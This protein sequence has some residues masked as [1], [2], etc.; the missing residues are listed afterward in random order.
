M[1]ATFD[2]QSHI[3]YAAME[4]STT[5]LHVVVQFY[6]FDMS[7]TILRRYDDDCEDC[8]NSVHLNI[9]DSRLILTV[10]LDGCNV[11]LQNPSTINFGW[12]E[13][14]FS[15]TEN[16]VT[17]QLNNHQTSKFVKCFVSTLT[18]NLDQVTNI[19]E[20]FEG[21]IKKFDVNFI[22]YALTINDKFSDTMYLPYATFN[23]VFELSEEQLYS[24]LFDTIKIPF[25]QS[26]SNWKLELYARFEILAR[27][28]FISIRSATTDY[29]M[30]VEINNDILKLKIKLDEYLNEVSIK[31]EAID[32]SWIHLEIEQHN[33]SWC[34]SVNDDKRTLIMPTD[35]FDELC[36]THLYIDMPYNEV[37]MTSENDV[38]EL[39][40]IFISE[41]MYEDLDIVWVKSNQL[42]L[43]RVDCNM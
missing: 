37:T 25:P 33:N 18:L 39:N 36:D 23:T 6:P 12:N 35:V 20:G 42:D 15:I 8:G 10:I 5:L 26:C 31:F 16:K 22:H 1:V 21:Y 27:G 32:S 14:S 24:D 11:T 28:N 17:L 13:V 38:I 7:G 30:S 9:I 3:K 2:K 4:T 34:M 41:L 19:G 43:H 29:V 40:C